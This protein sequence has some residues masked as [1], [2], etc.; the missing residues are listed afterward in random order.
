MPIHIDIEK[1]YLYKLGWQK[2]SEQLADSLEMSIQE[3]KVYI[4][5]IK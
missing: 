4:A 2:A 3:V 1:D 5:E